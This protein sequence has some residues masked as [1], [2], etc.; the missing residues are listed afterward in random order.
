MTQETSKATSMIKIQDLPPLPR[1]G[2]SEIAPYK[3]GKSKVSGVMNVVKLSS[4]ETPLGPSPDALAAAQA[5]LS[6]LEVYPDGGASEL[7]ATIAEIYG[8]DSTRIVCGTGSDNIIELLIR[9]YV[10]PG[11]E[12][13]YS[14]H[15]FLMYGI[16][17]LSVGGVPVA[18]PETN[19]T[20][21]VDAL[22]SCVTPRTKVVFIANPN[23]PTGTYISKSEVLRL[24]AGLPRSVLLV[25]DCAYAEYMEEDDYTDGFAMTDHPDANVVVTR[26]FSKI[27]GLAALRLGWGYAPHPIIDVLNRLR[28]PFN[29]TTPALMAGVA[30]LR[31]QDHMEAARAH[32]TQC[33]AWVEAELTKMGL[34]GPKSYGN[35]T[36]I[37]FDSAKTAEA[38]NTALQNEGYILRSVAEYGLPHC[39]RL[40]IGLEE[41][42]KAVITILKGF[43]AAN[44]DG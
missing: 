7:R 20:A 24:R 18:A 10:G 32:N 27:H 19:L 6:G 29:V 16:Y 22:L 30:A 8:L 12:V 35:F 15:G 9:G 31:D 33:R 40:S 41:D 25:L 1:P 2:I 13:L 26:T 23:N 42:C 37:C 44:H 21:N 43:L 38:A 14:Q 36:L 34:A 28:S 11:D 39:L 5:A 17:T 3:G 4:N